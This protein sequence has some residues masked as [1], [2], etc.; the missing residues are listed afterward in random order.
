MTQVPLDTMSMMSNGYGL[1]AAFAQYTLPIVDPPAGSDL[2]EEWEFF[3]GLAARLGLALTVR[4]QI[5]YALT[6]FE[7]DASSSPTTDELLEKLAAG[8]RVPLEQVKAFPHG[9]YFPEPACVVAPKDPSCTARLE[10][11]DDGM[12]ADLA[13]LDVD[14]REPPTGSTDP[15]RFPFRFGTSPGAAPLQ[16]VPRARADRA[17][18]TVEP[19]LY[20]PER[21]R[22]AGVGRRR[23]SVRRQRGRSDQSDS[24][25]GSRSPARSG[26]DD[27]LLW[28]TTGRQLRLHVEWK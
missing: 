2:L 5:H 11:G 22:A 9:A 13:V 8:S 23:G 6:P 25:A 4:R 28:R 14:H 27:T 1:E 21:H 7:V 18:S 3:A 15:T 24:P 17:R 12:M 19:R 20:E 10:V 16:L 26:L